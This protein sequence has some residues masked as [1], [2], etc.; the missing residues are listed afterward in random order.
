MKTEPEPQPTASMATEPLL[1]PLFPPPASVTTE[2]QVHPAASV[3]TE[4]QVHPAASVTTELQLQPPHLTTT[5]TQIQ[6]PAS[7]A[8]EVQCKP[9]ASAPN[10]PQQLDDS[11]PNAVTLAEDVRQLNGF[12]PGPF[13]LSGTNCYLIGGTGSE[14]I[15]VDTGEGKPEFK[16]L[17]SRTLA[18]LNNSTVKTVLLT[19]HHHDHVGGVS[20]VKSLSPEARVYKFLSDVD[21]SPSPY[22]PLS[23]AETFS[24]GRW[25]LRSIHTPGHTSDHCAFMLQD[26]LG[27]P[28]ALLAGDCVLGQGTTHFE[29]LSAFMTSLEILLNEVGQHDIPIYPGHGPIVSNA[30]EKLE[31]Y[32]RH[33]MDR[34]SQVLRILEIHPGSSATQIVQVTRH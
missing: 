11:L 32:R 25:T 28:V 6:P 16:D 26:E 8:T 9:L 2:L 14:M 19:H 7:V 5:E 22:L 24:T 23:H 12:N 3:T 18:G 30:R 1:Q 17:L 21:S 20:D 34:E 10:S 4:L 31:E 33:R 27:R 29:D 13:T 15:L